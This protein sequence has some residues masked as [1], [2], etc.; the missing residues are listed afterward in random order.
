M[1]GGPREREGATGAGGGDGGGGTLPGP[2]TG[3][4][5]AVRAVL[6]AGAAADR[7]GPRAVV[8]GGA[9]RGGRARLRPCFAALQGPLLA[10]WP[11]AS[12]GRA[13][14]AVLLGPTAACEVVA[15]APPGLE[16][17]PAGCV[18]EVALHP[19]SAARNRFRFL[20]GSPA[21]A[22][23]WQQALAAAPAPAWQARA[24]A[25]EA[26]LRAAEALVRKREAE[27]QSRATALDK[28]LAAARG[29][30]AAGR[31]HAERLGA[32]LEELRADNR[33]KT[34]RFAALEHANAR[35]AEETKAQA[36]A[37]DLAAHERDRA[38]QA[39]QAKVEAE[40]GRLRASHGEALRGEEGRRRAA[41][42]RAAAL[43]GERDDLRA[44]AAAL[45]AEGRQLAADLGAAREALDAFETISKEAGGALQLT[46][47][48]ASALKVA[49]AEARATAAVAREQLGRSRDENRALLQELDAEA[50]G[51]RAADSAAEAAHHRQVVEA[52]NH[53]AVR[54]ALEQAAVALRKEKEEREAE[55]RALVEEGRAQAQKHAETRVKLAAA[56]DEAQR[57]EARVE[58]MAGTIG[59]IE[60][61]KEAL[62]D[63]NDLMMAKYQNVRDELTKVLGEA[64]SKT[65]EIGDLQDELERAGSVQARALE[66]KEHLWRKTSQLEA[67]LLAAEQAAAEAQQAADQRQ[68][69][70]VQ[71]EVEIMDLTTS[72]SGAEKKLA[73]AEM[74]LEE[75]G[76][77][78]AELEATKEQ[79]AAVE[80][81]KA[82]FEGLA[83]SRL[84]EV[85]GGEAKAEELER[86]VAELARGLEETEQRHEE[87]LRNWGEVEEDL[88][89]LRKDMG[90]KD[91]LI[92]QLQQDKSVGERRTTYFKQL[93][94]ANMEMLTEFIDYVGEIEEVN[95]QVLQKY[96]AK[97]GDLDR[98]G[99]ELEA[100]LAGMFQG[101]AD[102]MDGHER[103]TKDIWRSVV[104]RV[105][106]KKRAPSPTKTRK[107]SNPLQRRLSG[108]LSFSDEAKGNLVAVSRALAES[109]YEKTFAQIKAI[110]E[111]HEGSDNSA[112]ST[113]DRWKLLTSLANISTQFNQ[114]Q[115][116]L[117]EANRE[118]R[119]G[120]FQVASSA[121]S[122]RVKGR[123]RSPSAYV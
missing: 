36:Q 49:E 54:Q 102:K 122:P 77:S 84:A 10:W 73:K 40:L 59:K 48:R 2:L 113:R 3:T 18:L 95:F 43:E 96:Q 85:K 28:A 109:N 107:E 104:A 38:E 46:Q 101:L 110:L 89:L 35:L 44:A 87:E 60:R 120:S 86:R 97:L 69:M 26:K 108:E 52:S 116:A 55:A 32:E 100:T 57:R 78:G 56:R 115:A 30:A 111:S 41:E 58:E 121:S 106:P 103:T 14:G 112:I 25:G 13:L 66:E 118:S 80:E 6:G 119:S 91:A 67:K 27:H 63:R 21:E 70:C 79:L 62:L 20:C 4:L 53:L 81:D 39:R 64:T 29:E 37:R 117:T 68:A 22:Q 12:D 15:E 16:D 93:V 11:S 65:G 105:Q 123:V 82:F 50:A 19:A 88:D 61:E 1:P 114:A 31:A 34:G 42:A 5:P 9:R 17:L 33:A 8:D 7:Q 83:D 98:G 74:A 45:R 47:E 71:F 24:L 94:D 72:L 23:A 99:Q 92:M 76:G 51:R 90:E 75:A